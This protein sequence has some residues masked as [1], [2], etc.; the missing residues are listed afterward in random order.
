M[1]EIIVDLNKDVRPWQIAALCKQPA[2]A[3]SFKRSRLIPYMQQ[4]RLVVL[5]QNRKK[6]RRWNPPSES[7]ETNA[8]NT[9]TRT[10][11]LDAV[12]TLILVTSLRMAYLQVNVTRNYIVGIETMQYYMNGSRAM[13]RSSVVMSKVVLFHTGLSIRKK[14]LATR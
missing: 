11:D 8:T 6:Q 1:L 5:H 14:L 9:S 3:P 10:F 7:L 2:R 4:L 13:R 12:E